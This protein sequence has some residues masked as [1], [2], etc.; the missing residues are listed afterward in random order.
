MNYL[1]I[2]ILLA[3]NN[4]CLAD[5]GLNYKKYNINSDQSAEV[6]TVNPDK[7]KI[8]I[9]RAQEVGPGFQTVDS[10]V[11]HFSALAG[12]NGGFFSLAGADTQNLLP[13]GLLKANS[14]WYSTTSKI[15]GAIG[16]DPRSNT[17]I[18]DRVRA[19]RKSGQVIIQPQ[20]NP[21]EINHWSKLPNIVGGGPLLIYKNKIITDFSVEKLRDD[22]IDQPHA[23]TAVGILSDKQWV[24]V[25]TTELTLAELNKFMHSLGCVFA[26]NLDGG[27]S[28][29]MYV[30]TGNPAL[31][32]RPVAD[33]LLIVKQ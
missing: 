28:S 11:R 21:K 13:A 18:F 9:A 16:W 10:M 26:L 15:R 14:K 7:L 22:F 27:G 24:L 12:I 32:G 1:I 4:I 19:V 3:F 29:A 25:I 31:L 33:A 2:L 23:R 5:D 30:A 20:L 8:I 6:L 17:V